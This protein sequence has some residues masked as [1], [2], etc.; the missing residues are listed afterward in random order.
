MALYKLAVNLKKGVLNL[1]NIRKALRLY[2]I[3]ILLTSLCV[4]CVSGASVLLQETVSRESS[5][6][7]TDP[8]FD[9]DS[10][11]VIHAV[12]S[13]S[14]NIGA[15][16]GASNSTVQNGPDKDIFYNCYCNGEWSKQT[17]V[18]NQIQGGVQV[19]SGSSIRDSIQPD[20]AIDLNN[21]SHIV[22]S[23][24]IPPSEIEADPSISFLHHF[25]TLSAD[26]SA[27]NPEFVS[28]EPSLSSNGLLGQSLL[29]DESSSGAFD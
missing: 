14:T 22:W 3:L 29:L 26:Y 6:D 21:V 4:F 2:L 17:L 9:V 25:N 23:A 28:G 8:S 15:K 1:S 12:W 10:S 27:G 18:N 13:D 16:I 5:S 11:G 19:L 24:L 7:S 20:V